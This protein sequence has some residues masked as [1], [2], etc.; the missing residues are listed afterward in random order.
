M[1]REQV[2][3]E[4]SLVCTVSEHFLYKQGPNVEIQWD[5]VCCPNKRHMLFVVVLVV[6]FFVFFLM[7][8]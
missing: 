5:C 8:I 2:W 1:E 3:G 6:I 7:K 4:D